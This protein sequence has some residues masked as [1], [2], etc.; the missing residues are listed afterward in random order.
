M[1]LNCY[2][3]RLGTGEPAQVR[4]SLEALASEFDITRVRSGDEAGRGQ[5][6]HLNQQMLH[7]SP[8]E[9]VAPRLAALGLKRADRAFWEAV[10]PN[11][12][13]LA[14]ARFW[15]EVCFGEVMPVIEDQ[16]FALR[17]AIAAA[18][19]MGR[20]DVG[21]LDAGGEGGHRAQGQG[22]VPAVAAGVDRQAARPRAAGAVATDRPSRRGATAAGENAGTGGSDRSG[23]C[24]ARDFAPLQHAHPRK[25]ALRAARFRRG[26]NV[27]LRPHRL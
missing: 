25:A 4:L 8:Y 9:A 21:L 1:A 10:R 26:Q 23:G 13:R 2:L 24:L 12:H 15:Y 22:A 14:D 20:G 16:E 3:A 6:Q 27:R 7:E 11:L 18:R 17:A 19:A 5:L